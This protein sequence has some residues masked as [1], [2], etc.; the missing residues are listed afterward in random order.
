MR[1]LKPKPEDTGTRLDIW[2]TSHFPQLSR[3]YIQKLIREGNV[4][5]NGHRSKA[6]S[7]VKP[8]WEV[9][10]NIPPPPT[11]NIIPENIP[12]YI[13]YE[14]EH[15]IVINK[16][17]GIVVHPS[18][19]HPCGTIV[20]ALIYHYNKSIVNLHPF[21]PGI[22]HRLDKD[23]SGIMIA[24]KTQEAFYSLAEQFKRGEIFKLYCAIV[25]GTPP[26]YGI[27]D[28]PI[29]RSISDRKKMSTKTV[30]GKHAITEYRVIEKFKFASF[31]HIIPKTGRTH[32]IRVH[33]A[34]IGFPVLGDVIYGKTQR[35]LVNEIN[36]HIRRH[37]L[38][39]YILAFNHPANNKRIQLKADLP[40]DMNN[41]L[42]ILR[43]Y[44]V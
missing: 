25:K 27:I 29:G 30:K 16:P 21:R 32:Q 28:K 5:V 2:L 22:V 8:D 7:K 20:N 31:L 11:T 40:E 33:L 9:S 37:M 4:L 34:S 39:A 26:P 3:N 17:P 12:L 19:G 24:A 36:L 13:I 1:V 43:N 6:H 14:D 15:I 41:L 18:A 35:I 10:I 23:T 38:H 42:S 44:I